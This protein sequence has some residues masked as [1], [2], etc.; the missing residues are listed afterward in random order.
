M[1][2]LGSYLG[3]THRECDDQYQQAAARVSQRHWPAAE[4]DFAAFRQAFL[5]HMRAEEA[6][7]FPVLQKSLGAKR[8]PLA[9]LRADHAHMRAVVQRIGNA[10]SERDV[11]AFFDNA[12]IMRS[13]MRQHRQKE[14]GIV[15]PIVE[16]YSAEQRARLLATIKGQHSEAEAES[17]A[18]A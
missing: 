11:D 14:S 13:L 4:R 15:H 2:T 7:M 5:R 17:G 12:T 3:D 16:G 18:P 1:N 8:G 6:L 10:L 9:E